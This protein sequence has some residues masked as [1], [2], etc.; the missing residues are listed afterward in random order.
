[1]GKKLKLKTQINGKK[2]H[3]RGLE[4]LIL[5]KIFI[6]TQSNPQSQ[7][8]PFQNTSDGLVFH[9]NNTKMCRIDLQKTLK[10]GQSNP[11]KKEQG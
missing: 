5:L 2:Y 4:E 8:N 6:T 3:A 10:N 7:Y 9:I 11:K 1:M